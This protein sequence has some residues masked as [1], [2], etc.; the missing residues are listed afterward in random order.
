MKLHNTFNS[1]LFVAGT[2]TLLLLLL[3]QQQ[4][5]GWIAAPPPFSSCNKKKAQR[6]TAPSRLYDSEQQGGGGGAF[7]ES[8]N[9]S[10]NN[11]NG[12]NNLE[13][14]FLKY[15]HQLEAERQRERDRMGAVRQLQQAFYLS[16]NDEREERFLDSAPTLH[17]GGAFEVPLWRVQWTEVPGRTNVLSVNEPMYTNST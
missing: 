6:C 15:K 4:C 12:S 10:S 11:N 2:P 14:D 3:S 17:N 13:K 16:K 9:N 1:V 8:E 5:W 7:E